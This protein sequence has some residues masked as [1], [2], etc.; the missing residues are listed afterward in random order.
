MLF[1]YCYLYFFLDAPDSYYYRTAKVGQTV[2]FPCPTKLI[3]ADVDWVRVET[4]G[5]PYETY[6]YYG[7]IGLDPYWRDPRFT[8]LDKN[9]SY[10]LV[11]QNV[12]VSDSAFYRCVDDSGLGKRFFYGL[13]VQGESSFCYML[14]FFSIRYF[15]RRPHCF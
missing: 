9:Q 13:T 11:I 2:K 12:T 14:T 1:R 8:V 6:I 4:H 10:T 15:V 7:N 5:R 3:H